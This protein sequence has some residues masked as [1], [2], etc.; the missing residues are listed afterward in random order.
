MTWEPLPLGVGFMIK[1]F[2]TVVRGSGA[3]VGKGCTGV[4]GKARVTPHHPVPQG[5]DSAHLPSSVAIAKP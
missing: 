4:R 5:T 3:P 2:S 1:P